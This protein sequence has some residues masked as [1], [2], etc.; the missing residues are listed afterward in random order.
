MVD[1]GEQIRQWLVAHEYS[2]DFSEPGFISRTIKAKREEW[3][4]LYNLFTQPPVS[5]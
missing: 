4:E 3:N 1:K 2:I 5:G